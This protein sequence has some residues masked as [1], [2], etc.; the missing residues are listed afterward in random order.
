MKEL[1]NLIGILSIYAFLISAL[2][3][4]LRY[5][6]FNYK[7]ISDRIIFGLFYLSDILSLVSSITVV[8]LNFT[9][10]GPLK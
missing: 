3:L 5:T 9:V 10:Q 6:V 2:F 8:F 4:L 7:A 1:Y